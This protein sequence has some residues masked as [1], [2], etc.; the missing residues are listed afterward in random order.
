MAK[1]RYKRTPY[2]HQVAAL[3]KLL[4]SNFGGALLMDPRTG[5]TQVCIDYASVLHLKGKVSR[6]LIVCPLG[7]MGVWEDEI[8]AVCPFPHRITVWDKKGRKEEPL[9]KFGKDVLDFV[10]VNYD[11]FAQPGAKYINRKGEEVRSDTRGGKY[12]LRN[13]FKA[14]QPQLIILDESHRIKSP[15]AAKTRSMHAIG[16][17][18]D[19]RVIATGTAVTKA[20][21]IFDLYAQW[22]FLNPKGWIRHHTLATFKAEY[23]NFIQ[24]V[25]PNGGK[26]EKW[27]GNNEVA[28][29]RLRLHLHKDSFAI[30]R[31]ECYDLP[32][33][34]DQIIH[35]PLTGESARLY[36]EMVEEMIAQIKTGEM[37]EAQIKLVLR[38]RLCQITSGM[39]KTNPTPQHPKGRL[40]RV[41]RDKLDLATDLLS[42]W[43]EAEEKVVVAAR[44]RGDIASLLA[45]HNRGRAL[46]GVR[47][48][49]LYGGISRAERD[50]NIKNFRAHQG[51]AMFIMQPSAGALGIDL[52]TSAT[53]LW[54]SL[55][56]SYVDYTQAKDRIALSKRGT[57]HSH[58]LAEG[59][60]DFDMYH[61]L[62]EDRDF[63]KM[64]QAS[65]DRLR[66]SF[67]R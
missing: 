29:A 21:R 35:V 23:G 14:W 12:D 24:K 60:I 22:K 51:A 15:S 49:E 64:V 45:Q 46:S 65:P 63:V 38:L 33:S 56:D 10:I 39:V 16:P 30:T 36:D 27:L 53:M 58:L 6:V 50:A 61:S 59:T 25:A 52:S 34:R 1:Y 54:Y 55:I 62:A 37:T 31:D 67:R 3:K 57:V 8:P 47:T 18:A 17:I 40:V 5:K 19:Y 2:R 28:I 13:K 4:K 32:P 44:F 48:F 42:D 41:G 20:K 11:A 9:P 66:R 7:V 43:Y 26:Y